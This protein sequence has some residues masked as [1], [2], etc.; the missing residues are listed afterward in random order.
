M[1]CLEPIC[2]VWRHA[3][4]SSERRR[5]L[6]VGEEDVFLWEKK[7]PSLSAGWT[8]KHVAGGTEAPKAIQGSPLVNLAILANF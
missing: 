6:L 5:C 4:S 7:H 1:M 2:V 8:N 3:M